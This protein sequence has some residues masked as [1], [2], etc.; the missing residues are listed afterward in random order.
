[1]NRHSNV[2]HRVHGSPDMRLRSPRAHGQAKTYSSYEG[3]DDSNEEAEKA[4]QMLAELRDLRQSVQVVLE[5][6]SVLPKQL[7]PA[8]TDDTLSTKP[9]PQPQVEAAASSDHV[10]AE[11]SEDTI[12]LIQL[13]RK[14]AATH[15][16]AD[17]RILE[18]AAKLNA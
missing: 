3:Y 2:D 7:D 11:E 13:R 10:D 6:E 18:M 8:F 4:K 1:M 15:A 5:S 12:R 16:A 14:V 9:D 17:S